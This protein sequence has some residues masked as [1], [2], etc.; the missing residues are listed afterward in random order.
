VELVEELV[1]LVREGDDKELDE[2]LE[3]L[4]TEELVVNEVV[5]ELLTLDDD[6]ELAAAVLVRLE[7]LVE[8]T[9]DEEVG[10]AEEELIFNV[11]VL[12]EEIEELVDLLVEPATAVNNGELEGQQKTYSRRWTLSW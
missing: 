1:E 12:E 11:L 8:E 6:E 3:V 10:K 9:V 2:E 5:T 7:E 4:V